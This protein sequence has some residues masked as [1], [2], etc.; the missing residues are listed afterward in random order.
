MKITRQ[1]VLALCMVAV[2]LF[3]WLAPLDSRA[4]E[5]LDAGLKRALVSFATSRAL[6][7]VISVEQGTEI[8]AHQPPVGYFIQRSQSFHFLGFCIACDT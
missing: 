1:V 7:G 4:I 6:N 8:V 3:S 2:I 5:Q